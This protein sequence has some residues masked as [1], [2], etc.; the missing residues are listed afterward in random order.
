MQLQQAA[1]AKTKRQGFRADVLRVPL[2][3]SLHPPLLSSFVQYRLQM[4][5]VLLAVYTFTTRGRTMLALVIS[6]YVS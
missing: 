5:Q 1:A 6:E 3:P 2:H 4:L